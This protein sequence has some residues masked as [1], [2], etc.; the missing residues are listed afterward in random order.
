MNR[1]AL[2]LKLRKKNSAN[3]HQ[4]LLLRK[5]KHGLETDPSEC[6]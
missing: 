4:L 2:S 1:V 5:F 3:T 6:H